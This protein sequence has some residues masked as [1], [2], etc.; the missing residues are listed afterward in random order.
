MQL[1]DTFARVCRYRDMIIRALP[2]LR[3]AFGHDSH[4]AASAAVGPGT[5]AP[6]EHRAVPRGARGA[7]AGLLPP[8]P[9]R[10]WGLPPCSFL[11]FEIY[12]FCKCARIETI[13]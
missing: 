12:H 9:A 3:E 5:G 8:L 11:S 13:F 7:G 10:E 1:N 6:W 4:R 2:T